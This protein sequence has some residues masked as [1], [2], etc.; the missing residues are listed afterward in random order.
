MGSHR[1][2]RGGALRSVLSSGEGVVAV[3]VGDLV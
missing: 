1:Y 2:D 3:E